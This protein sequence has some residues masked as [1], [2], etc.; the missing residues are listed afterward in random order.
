[1]AVKHY[2][3]L[4]AVLALIWGVQV[5]NAIT[6][7]ALN[8]WFGL[9]PR[10]FGGLDGIILMPLLH[11]SFGHAASNSVPLVVLGGLLTLTAR[12]HVFAATAM[13]IALGGLAVWVLGNPAVHVGASGLIFGWFGYLVARGVVEKRPIPVLAAL[14]VGLAYGGL[15]WG[16]LPGQ[17][18]VSWESHLFGAIA[19]VL[20]AIFLR[21]D[22]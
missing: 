7:Y 20:A 17:P 13:I 14:G 3:W 11:G 6:G 16:V 10:S 9:I 1:M 21:S 19:G 15:V 12:A 8:G 4:V 5:V 2:G 18:G 22:S